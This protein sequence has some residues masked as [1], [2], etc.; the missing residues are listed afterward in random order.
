[1]TVDTNSIT[2]ERD[3]IQQGDEAETLLNNETFSKVINSLVENT[4]QQ[5]V[6]TKPGEKDKREQNYNH[7]RALID[8]VYTL[9]Q[10]VQVRDEIVAG[11]ELSDNNGE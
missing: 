10:R 3:L 1:M 6:D 11:N 4:F 7:Y 9:R 5:F 8:I 2:K